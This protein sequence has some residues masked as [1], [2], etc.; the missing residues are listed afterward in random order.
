MRRSPGVS[1]DYPARFAVLQFSRQSVAQVAG[2]IAGDDPDQS[3][4][5]RCSEQ[6]RLR[7]AK[8]LVALRDELLGARE[9]D[10]QL[11]AVEQPATGHE[12]VRRPFDVHDPGAGGRRLDVAV[13]DPAAGAIGV[14]ELH[15][16]VDDVGD[17]LKPA[18]VP[19]V[20]LSSSSAGTSCLCSWRPNRTGP[21]FV[22]IR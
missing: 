21:S 5:V 2:D 18:A 14:R 7:A 15:D 13:G 8:V 16:A 3:V 22:P 17:G 19:R 20:P 4:A 12:A 1:G 11:H 6:G 9:V 10:P